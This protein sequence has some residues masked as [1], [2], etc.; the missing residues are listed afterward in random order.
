MATAASPSPQSES[1]SAHARFRTSFIALRVTRDA[2]AAAIFA[3]RP[4][5]LFRRAILLDSYYCC[6][7]MEIGRLQS[8]LALIYHLI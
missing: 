2:V 8:Y 4:S 5:S 1:S 6:E 3:T 7:A